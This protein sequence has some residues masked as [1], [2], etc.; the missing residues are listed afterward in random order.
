[1][2][3]EKKHIYFRCIGS[4]SSHYIF[5]YH[6]SATSSDRDK[7]QRGNGGGGSGPCI[8]HPGTN[9]RHTSAECS[10]NPANMSKSNSSS[11]NSSNGT[12]NGQDR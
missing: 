2:Q 11:N 3:V 4:Y 1:M 9:I 8:Y 7:P 12:P 5:S 10:K 6:N